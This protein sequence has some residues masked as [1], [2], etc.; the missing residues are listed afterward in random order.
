MSNGKLKPICRLF[1]FF[2]RFHEN[3]DRDISSVYQDF[4]EFVSGGI[5]RTMDSSLNLFIFP[6]VL[7]ILVRGKRLNSIK[8]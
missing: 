7:M 8:E 1:L 5:R 6:D 4:A 2:S 3:T